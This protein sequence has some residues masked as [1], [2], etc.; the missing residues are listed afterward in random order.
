MGKRSRAPK[1]TSRGAQRLA[2][3][4]ENQKL[5]LFDLA[6]QLEVQ[7]TSVSRYENGYRPTLEVALKIE[8]LTEGEVRTEDWLEEVRAAG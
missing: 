4:R 1:I 2:R 8:S 7:P 5:S 3:W 6:I